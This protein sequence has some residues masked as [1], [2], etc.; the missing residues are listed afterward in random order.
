MSM[1]PERAREVGD[2][3]L[4]AHI[5]G[6]KPQALAPINPEQADRNAAEILL[7][8]GSE[9]QKA[10]VGITSAFGEIIKSNLTETKPIAGVR[11]IPAVLHDELITLM[12][13]S[14]AKQKP[15]ARPPIGRDEFTSSEQPT[16]NRS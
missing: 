14:G 15:S 11:K 5:F 3:Y 6:S 13:D 2:A 9:R 12:R 10:L 7:T 4:K 16:P 1:T 8:L